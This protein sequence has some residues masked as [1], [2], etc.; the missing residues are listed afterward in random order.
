MTWLSEMQ[1]KRLSK[2]LRK[3]ATQKAQEAKNARLNRDYSG[4]DYLQGV[5]KGLLLSAAC[6]DH[7][8]E[9]PDPGAEYYAGK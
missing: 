4:H 2:Y 7:N 6:L 9:H 3:I 8:V 1:L 5:A